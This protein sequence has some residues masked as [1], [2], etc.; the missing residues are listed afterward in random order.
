VGV[1][2]ATKILPRF[3]K[4]PEMVKKVLEKEKKIK[5]RTKIQTF[6]STTTTN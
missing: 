1:P 3:L 4:I 5:Q 6:P 2:N